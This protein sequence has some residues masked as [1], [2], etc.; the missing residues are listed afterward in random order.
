VI[1]WA[2][3][4]IKDGR[5]ML[6]VTTTLA[7]GESRLLGGRA[8]KNQQATAMTPDSFP[9]HSSSREQSKNGRNERASTKR[10]PTYRPLNGFMR[11][12]A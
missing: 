4:K 5:R 8:K 10:V 11:A 9:L 12:G 3:S 7:I 6:D 2:I 1:K